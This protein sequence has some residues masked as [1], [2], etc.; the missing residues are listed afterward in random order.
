MVFNQS[1]I[2]LFSLERLLVSITFFINSSGL[3]RK[4]KRAALNKV[5]DLPVYADYSLYGQRNLRRI[6]DAL[7]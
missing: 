1:S 3:T 5:Y 2:R 4:K 6:V 7:S